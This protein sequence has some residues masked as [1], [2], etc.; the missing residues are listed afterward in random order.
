M[1]TTSPAQRLIDRIER[2][3]HQDVGRNVG[4]LFDATAG[5]LWRSAH[6][7][8]TDPAPRIGLLTG[9]F[10]PLGRPPA[11]ET[12]GPI[13]AAL[14]AAGLTKA[15]VPVRMMTDRPCESGCAA[16]LRGAGLGDL[17]LDVVD[18]DAPLEPTTEIWRK[19][20]I[21]WAMAIERCGR[22][23]SG[24]PRNM[25]GV[26]ISAHTAA[27]D[28]LFLAG[29]WDTIAIADGGN[30]MGAGT[31]PRSLMARHVAHGDLI[32]CVTP[33]THL[34]MAG[35]SH[36]GCYAM[37]AALA[38]LRPDWRDAMLSCLDPVLDHAIMRTMMTEGPAVD[39]VS[40]RQE[41]TIDTLD[42]TMHHRK[43][44]AIR[45]ITAGL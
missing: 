11:A 30:E 12:D 8:A 23:Q 9:F 6:A 5:G 13:G 3:I 42:M 19:A 1:Q 25:R 34:V 27:L 7:L 16:A 45:E 41:P 17:P 18:V 44:A 28:D 43:L 14:L 35:V 39:G 20:G 4:P 24:P 37:L 2:L 33:A 36:W 26:D 29:P 21:N 10:V 15:G 40:Q 22:T 38:I 32:A 31:L